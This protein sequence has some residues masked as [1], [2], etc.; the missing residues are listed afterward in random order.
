MERE[1]LTSNDN[2][3]IASDVN[4]L[5]QLPL[6]E[7]SK[8]NKFCQKYAGVHGNQL[9]REVYR[10]FPYYAINSEIS[11]K[12]MSKD[13]LKNIIRHIPSQEESVLFTI[14]YEGTSFE[15]YLNRLIQNNVKTLVDVRKNPL[16]RKYGF[17]K[18]TLS[19]TVQKLGIKYEH[20]PTLGIVSEKRKT[21]KTEA[22]YS[23]LF[24][25]YDRTVI[26]QNNTALN[27]LLC[28]IEE[29]GRMAITCFE[30]KP[31]MCHRSRV[32]K[33]MKTLPNW[34]YKISH[35]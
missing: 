19:E 23:A 12:L 4:Y 18:K 17:S 8:I 11:E 33:A 27:K 35:I 32:A 24:D 6:A 30:E 26:Q 14:G 1:F 13:E 31:C 9:I 5:Y 15:N 34:N 28:L 29:D 10:A 3:V 16:S 21:L 25:E 22:D 2:W 20:M 7:Q